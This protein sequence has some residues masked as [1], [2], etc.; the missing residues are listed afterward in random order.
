MSDSPYVSYRKLFIEG[1]DQRHENPA[2][3]TQL[4]RQASALAK[5]EGDLH[6]ALFMDHWILQTVISI[7]DD[8]ALGLELAVQT[9]VEARKPMYKGQ[10]ERICVH[11]DLIR[12]YIGI[13]PIGQSKLIQ[14]AIDYM[15]KEADPSVQCYFCLMSIRST[16]ELAFGATDRA[17][18]AITRYLSECALDDDHHRAIALMRR[19][20]LEALRQNWEAALSF[21]NTAMLAIG[22]N[23]QLQD[24]LPTMLAAKALASHHLGQADDAARFAQQAVYKA[25]QFPYPMNRVY[26]K[27]LCDYY[28]LTGQAPLALEQ[29]QH[30]LAALVGKGQP[31]WESLVRLEYARLSKQ[32]GQPYH[33]QGEA[34][35]ALAAKLK[36]PNIVLDPLAALETAN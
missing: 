20:E 23:E 30:Q 35:R 6:E 3:A 9:T 34:I 8:Y 19:C 16:F 13:D 21:A 7:S 11:D 36:Q 1:F 27:M 17:E 10:M 28:E 2:K 14:D 31:Y 15:E 5:E 12:A 33:E 26:Y 32:L 4:M 22:S 29:R 25:A 18:N 24:E